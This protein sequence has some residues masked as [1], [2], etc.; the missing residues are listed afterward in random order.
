MRRRRFLK[1]VLGGCAAALIPFPA[2]PKPLT[3]E[4]VKEAMR[5]AVKTDLNT[6]TTLDEVFK[7]TY[8]EKLRTCVPKPLLLMEEPVEIFEHRKLYSMPITLT[9]RNGFT[10]AG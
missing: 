1:A 2:G 9:H 10:E 5:R 8:G 4:V 3:F 7:R 6:V